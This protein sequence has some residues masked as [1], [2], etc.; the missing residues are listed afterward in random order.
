MY[1]RF[2]LLGDLAAPEKTRLCLHLMSEEGVLARNG[3]GMSKANVEP[4]SKECEPSNMPS[5]ESRKENRLN[6]NAP[7]RRLRYHMLSLV[8]HIHLP[9][10]SPPPRLGMSKAKVAPTSK[11][12]EPPTVP[13]YESRKENR[14]KRNAPPRRLRY[15]ML[16]L[17]AHIYLPLC[18]GAGTR[19]RFSRR[20]DSLRGRQ[21]K[22]SST[23]PTSSGRGT[24][25]S[26]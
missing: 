9:L 20:R 6:R 19:T 5:Y 23:R 7:P 21:S 12:C 8:S 2:G 17:D 13:S 15:H 24:G 25:R 14:R 22:G 26:R 11:E 1:C 18:S 4:I 16:S 3:L 10:C